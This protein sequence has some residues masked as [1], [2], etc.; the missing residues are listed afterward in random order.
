[1]TD[2][3]IKYQTKFNKGSCNPFVEGGVFASIDISKAMISAAL[4]GVDVHI[5]DTEMEK[6]RLKYT[7]NDTRSLT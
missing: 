1:M 5:R 2:G 7:S 3:P 4:E 6:I